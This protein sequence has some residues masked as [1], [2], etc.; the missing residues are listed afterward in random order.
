MK[1]EFNN[2]LTPEV[3]EKM[4]KNLI[5]LLIFSVVMIFAGL[6]SAYIV[7][8]G[9]AFWLKYPFPSALWI[10]TVII[11]LSSIILQ[12]G[13]NKSK[14][15]FSSKTKYFVISSFILGIAFV[16]YQVKAYNQLVD[17]GIH[18]VNSH[19]IVTDGRY[20]DYFE[21]K[22]KGDFVE[23]DGNDYL[24]KGKKMNEK[25]F[26]SL[27]N[28][29]LQFESFQAGK[30]LKIKGYGKDFILYFKNQ[31]LALLNNELTL[32]DGKTLEYTDMARL[33][34]LAINIGDF[35]GDFFVKGQIGKDFHIYYKG[36]ELGYKDRNLLYNGKVL[37]KYYQLKIMETA[38]TASAYL[39]LIGALHLLHILLTIIYFGK[40]M[41]NILIGKT[42][43]DNLLD[44]KGVAIFW[45]FLGLLWIYL[46]VFLMYIH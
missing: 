1:Q 38:D 46:F 22:Y 5:Y 14:S 31:P 28:F 12:I 8:M 35:R 7:S 2:E 37:S 10:S 39:I 21:V 20:G 24:V 9:D 42:S 3:K 45:H 30:A 32:P 19:I 18:G 23:V 44:L 41:V 25:S 40:Y 6:T 11:V 13:I 15:N 16:F 43:F 4:R 34:S 27:Q 26:A 33:K 29:M 17:A 36:K